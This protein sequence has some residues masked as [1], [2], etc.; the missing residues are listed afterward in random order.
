MAAMSNLK[1]SMV[2]SWIESIFTPKPTRRAAAVPV[3][4]A[5]FFS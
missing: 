1:P 3:I 4:S 5:A 2:R